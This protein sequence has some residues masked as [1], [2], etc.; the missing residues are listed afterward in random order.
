MTYSFSPPRIEFPEVDTAAALYHLEQLIAQRA[1]EL[2]RD[3]PVKADDRVLWARAQAEVLQQHVSASP[4]FRPERSYPDG[5]DAL[6]LNL[7]R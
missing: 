2:A 3:M 4:G 5:P 6:R 7:C 1:D